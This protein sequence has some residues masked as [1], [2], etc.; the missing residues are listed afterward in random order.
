MFP[1]V[2]K[3]NG[4]VSQT[5]RT[6]PDTFATTMLE[7]GTKSREHVPDELA[8]IGIST[9]TWR[10]TGPDTKEGQATYAVYLASQDA[11]GDGFPDEGE[12]PVSCT[13]FAFT[14][15][16]LQVMPGCELTPLPEEATQ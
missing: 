2:D 9:S 6:G 11:D 4:W 10:L 5:V 15:R 1:D 3:S 16:R 7:Y 14:G 12:E 13:P 8:T